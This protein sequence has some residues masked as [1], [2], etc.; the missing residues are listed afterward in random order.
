MR[1]N[2]YLFMVGCAVLTAASITA[3]GSQAAAVVPNVIRVENVN[4]EER[5]TVV[6]NSSE[7]VKVV[8]D[9]AEIIYGITTEDED[10]AECQ[11]KNTEKLDQVIEFLKAQGYEESSIKTSGFYMNPKYDW[12]G[13][14]QQLIGYQMETQI[15][16]T[17]V[18]VADVG[19]LLSKTVESG[20]NEIQN[21]SYFSSA[22]DQAYEEA[23]A[24]AVETAKSKAEA[25]A[26][27]GGCQVTDVLSIVEKKDNQ[28]GR[29]V[30]SGINTSSKLSAA[31]EMAGGSADMAVMPGEMKVT[32]DITVEF[33]LLPR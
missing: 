25:L 7:T 14:R 13:N 17:D 28:Y 5:N 16:V 30:E 6:I 19:M 33:R 21:V 31:V 10:A 24:K 20:A 8:P 22:Y 32:A 29:Y 11:Q 12:S 1:K 9:M 23:L 27:A 26:H 18:P 2:N 4:E 15:T 3:C